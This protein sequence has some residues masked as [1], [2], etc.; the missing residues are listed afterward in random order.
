MTALDSTRYVLIGGDAMIKSNG[1]AVLVEFNPWP[2][3]SKYERLHDCING[4]KVCRRLAILDPSS[5]NGYR[6]TEPTAATDIVNTEYFATVIRDTAAL[7]MGLET[8]RN[9]PNPREIQDFKGDYCETCQS[10]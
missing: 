5:E 2:D 3:I 6:I 8:A 4:T 10:A 1:K 7:V 9:I